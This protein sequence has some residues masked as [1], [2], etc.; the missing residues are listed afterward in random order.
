MAPNLYP[1]LGQGPKPELAADLLCQCTE[2]N[3]MTPP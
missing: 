2:L 1:P 3:P